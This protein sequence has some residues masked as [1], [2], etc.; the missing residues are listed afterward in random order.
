MDGDRRTLEQMIER[1]RIDIVLVLMSD[2][3]L[4]QSEDPAIDGERGAALREAASRIH[5]AAV[6][7][8]FLLRHG[9]KPEGP[10]F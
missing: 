7:A 1:R 10:M 2:I 3:L 9:N 5:H 6:D 8:V 4:T